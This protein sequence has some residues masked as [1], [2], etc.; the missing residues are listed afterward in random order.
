MALTSQGKK[1][2]SKASLCG[3]LQQGEPHSAISAALLSNLPPLPETFPCESAGSDK[4]EARKLGGSPRSA[5]KASSL[6]SE[7][8]LPPLLL[9]DMLCY[10]LAPTL[11]QGKNKWIKDTVRF[12]AIASDNKK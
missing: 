5:R 4:Q 2:P 7:V 10:R 11:L 8:T 6:G 1:G 9:G 12:K 3:F